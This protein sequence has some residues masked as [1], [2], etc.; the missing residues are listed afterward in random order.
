MG[1]Q[2][3]YWCASLLWTWYVLHFVVIFKF[4]VCPFL[5][6]LL[7]L[8]VKCD[9]MCLWSCGFKKGFYS[10]QKCKYFMPKDFQ[11]TT[12]STNLKSQFS[13]ITM[14]VGFFFIAWKRFHLFTRFFSFL[15]KIYKI[16]CLIVWLSYISGLGT[17]ALKCQF[18]HASHIS[19]LILYDDLR[20]MNGIMEVRILILYWNEQKRMTTWLQ[21]LDA[22]IYWFLSAKK[23]KRFWYGI[24]LCK[25]VVSPDLRVQ[26]W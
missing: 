11:A 6:S 22:N 19:F 5:Y 23:C 15:F 8:L 13:Q 17:K 21:T 16:N 20:H 12:F 18:L 3:A 24:W 2:T 25:S 7:V 1:L 4:V 14:A 10:M 26:I 9:Q